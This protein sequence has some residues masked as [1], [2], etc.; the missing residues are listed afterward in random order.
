MTIQMKGK[1]LRVLQV[2]GKMCRAGAE[3]LL[4]N[5]Y[6][7]IDREHIQFDFLTHRQEQGD[8]DEEIMALGG[9]IYRLCPMSVKNSLKY[10]RMLQKFFQEHPDYRIIHSHLDAMSSLPLAAAKRAGVPVRIAHSHNTDFPRDMR[11]PMRLVAQG[12]IPLSA[13]HYFA[14]SKESARFLFPKR[15]F[16]EG[17][18]TVLK[19]AIVLEN[20]VYLEEKRRQMREKLG[21]GESTFIIGHV[22]RFSKQ[23]NHRKL[24]QVFSVLH[25]QCPDSVLIL[26]GQGELWE[27]IRGLCAQLELEKAIWFL[28]VRDDIESLMQA[29]DL[30]LLPSLYEGFPVVGVE[31]QA[32]GLPCLFSNSIK[33][34]I[35]LTSG[36]EFLPLRASDEIWAQRALALRGK[37][38]RDNLK[39]L[40]A[41]GFDIAQ[42]A[43]QMM[44]FY[45]NAAEVQWKVEE[46]QIT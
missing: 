9:K 1:P 2:V 14:C 28:G 44:E 10:G 38:R 12:L 15:I 19:N 42:Q 31:A 16:Q 7:S 27:E 35:A 43:E 36:V 3:T 40:R 32:A 46:G 45:L 30:F 29:F 22:G 13:T 33:K 37:P 34:D 26:A 24:L 5:L 25:K 18:Y 11:Y 20:F 21:F 41:K 23:K 39:I 8:Y 4:M 17:N 6:R